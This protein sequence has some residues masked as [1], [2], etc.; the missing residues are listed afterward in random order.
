MA[1]EPAF[2]VYVHWPFCVAKCPYCDFNSHVRARIDEARWRSALLADLD[3]EAD[4][5]PGRRVSTVFFGGGTPSLMEPATV[6]AVIDRI[7]ARW[8]FG[9]DPE[10]TLEANPGSVEAGRFRGY[11][12]AGVNRASLGVQALDEA[13]L[14]ALGRKHSLAEAI[15][16]I[17]LA[18]AV[19]PRSSFDLIYARPG[20]TPA[21]WESELDRA[22]AFA[23]EHLSLYQLTIEPGTRF[24]TLAERGDLVPPD[25][26]TQA[27]LH[28]ATGEHMERAGFRAYEV[29]NFARAGAACR[30]NLIYW[31][32]EDWIGVGPGAHGRISIAGGRRATSRHRLPETW[33]S[34]VERNGH[35]IEAEHDLAADDAARE[36]LLMGLRLEEGIDAARF[37]AI[38]GR[39]L[40]TWID[41][42]AL[43]RLEGAGFLAREAGSLRA[44]DAGRRVLNAVIAALVR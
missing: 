3:R 8:G 43:D 16:A 41:P 27:A 34:A 24:H 22:L 33:L 4:A 7:A 39:D 23:T 9:P 40:W 1:P 35:G 6:A 12:A 42:S 44:T 19:F 5:T 29:S 2:G 26:D 11:R 13:A 30:H 25:E 32:S 38:T 18:Q 17:G 36:A 15:A 14:A 21:A 28:E 20:Q 37:Q 10:I 31:R